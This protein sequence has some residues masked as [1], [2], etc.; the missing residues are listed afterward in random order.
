MNLPCQI[1]ASY[2][3]IFNFSTKGA[4]PDKNGVIW[5]ALDHDFYLDIPDFK[6]NHSISDIQWKIGTTRIARF[7]KSKATSM[8]TYEVFSNGTLKIK[9]LM[10]NYSNT[11]RVNVYDQKGKNMLEK[12]FELKIL[13]A[14]S[15]PVISWNCSNKSLTC[16]VIKGSEIELKLY[17]NK[18]K[19][20]D[21]L[22]KVITYNWI[23][24]SNLSFKCT[25]SNKVSEETSV[26][27][28]RCS[29]K[30]LTI[31][32]IISICGGG[33]ILILCV[34]LLIFCI[35]NRKKQNRRRNAEELEIRA[36]KITAD[37]RG[38]R[39][40][41]TPGSTPQKP[42]ASQPPAPP[43]HRSQAPGHRPVPPGPRAQHQQQKRLQPPLGPQVPQQK[44]PPLPR[45]RVQQKPPC[46]AE[47]SS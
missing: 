25:A 45:P 6:A 33:F 9:N 19:L 44:G 5:G 14:V 22:Q 46:G 16:E 42:A 35:N 1:L 10:R 15:K 39:P 24:S 20:K 37:E 43:G 29:E 8:E 30:G 4:F 11:Y 40:L 41:Q 28:I 7:T 34:A 32:H 12:A 13:E 18:K 17:K 31:Y 2:L 21:I 23:P 27:D 26:V 3:L 38:R 36:H 47:E